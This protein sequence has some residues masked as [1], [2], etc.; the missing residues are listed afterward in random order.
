MKCV[1]AI[2]L[3]LCLN[4]RSVIW[5]ESSSKNGYTF[6]SS[7]LLYRH[8]EW[9]ERFN[10]NCHLQSKSQPFDVIFVAVCMMV[11]GLICKGERFT[12]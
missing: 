5:L 4:V 7:K 3:T 6:Q 10:E 11:D 8:F 12:A 9:N 1:L 2:V